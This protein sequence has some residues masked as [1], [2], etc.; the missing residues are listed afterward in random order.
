MG[1]GRKGNWEKWKE[2]EIG[3][4]RKGNQRKEEK[5]ERKLERGK[6]KHGWKK[7]E[8]EGSGEREQKVSCRGEEVKL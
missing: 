3:R 1:R 7:D 5:E 4:I 8:K 6:K 2:E